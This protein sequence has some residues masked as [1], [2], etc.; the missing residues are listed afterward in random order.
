MNLPIDNENNLECVICS[1]PIGTPDSNGKIEQPVELPCGHTLGSKCMDLWRRRN[2][3]C[4]LCRHPLPDDGYHARQNQ[5]PSGRR[6]LAATNV[7]RAEISRMRVRIYHQDEVL[8]AQ[9]LMIR[10]LERDMDRNR[11]SRA[12]EATNLASYSHSR[13][14]VEEHTGFRSVIDP[15]PATSARLR[16][17]R[18]EALRI[19]DAGLLAA[20]MHKLDL[21]E[22][23]EL[24]RT[25]SIRER[26]EIALQYNRARESF[27]LE[28]PVEGGPRFS[29]EVIPEL[30]RLEEIDSEEMVVLRRL[31]R[32]L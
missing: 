4:P 31:K 25:E 10:E 11:R 23:S 20:Y 24:Q 8:K 1:S 13:R 6:R 16:V 19:G 17:G 2:N 27:I 18:E 30:R 12:T 22:L 5:R 32:E 26:A 14:A 7:A 29:N 9:Q 15:D 21:Q 3:T 28:I